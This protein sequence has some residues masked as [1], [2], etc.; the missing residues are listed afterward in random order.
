MNLSDKTF[1]SSKDF[2]SR[3][4]FLALVEKE[5]KLIKEHFT[6]EEIEKITVNKIDGDSEYRCIY[7]TMVGTC[8]SKRVLNFIKNNIDL[9]IRCFRRPGDN[10]ISFKKV[11]FEQ[12]SYQYFVTPLEEY[13]ISNEFDEFDEDGYNLSVQER[14][15]H[16]INLITS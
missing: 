6:K 14:I 8:N 5:A 13:I 2:W 1:I 3:P 12:R 16:A 7:G 10:S 11:D 9:L 4:D 15:N